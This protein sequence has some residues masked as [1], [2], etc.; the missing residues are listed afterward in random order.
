MYYYSLL[1]RIKAGRQE[2][3]SIRRFWVSFQNATNRRPYS[4][5]P[6]YPKTHY[7]LKI[8]RYPPLPVPA[9]LGESSVSRIAPNVLPLNPA[10][11]LPNTPLLAVLGVEPS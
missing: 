7:N 3:E 8:S 6:L 11:D 9:V 1:R 2:N 10:V 5:T 4:K